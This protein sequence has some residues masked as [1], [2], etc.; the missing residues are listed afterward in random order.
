MTKLQ[1]AVSWL[2]TKAEAVSILS[3][4]QSDGAEENNKPREDD[5]A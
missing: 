1:K 4:F 3:S 2:A 5:T